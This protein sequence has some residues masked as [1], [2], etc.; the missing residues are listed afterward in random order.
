[1]SRLGTNY[2]LVGLDISAV[3]ATTLVPKHVFIPFVPQYITRHIR[4]LHTI[5]V[6]YSRE[7]VNQLVMYRFVSSVVGG[8]RIDTIQ[9]EESSANYSLEPLGPGESVFCNFVFMTNGCV[10][11][12][13]CVLYTTIYN[14]K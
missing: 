2:H 13:V 10:N 3:Q 1:M 8:S 5:V 11:V 7:I 6:I 12:R 14:K 9:V 4:C